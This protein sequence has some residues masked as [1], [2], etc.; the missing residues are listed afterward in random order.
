MAVP[1]QTPYIEHIGNGVTTSFSLGFQ[2]ESKDHLIVLVD[3]IEPPI[4]TWSL[5]GGNVVF[6]IAPAAGKKI[7]AQ[8]NTPFSRNVDYQSY[9]NSFRPP[10]VNK[11]F[12]WIWWKLQELGVADWILGARIDALK[13]YVDRKDDELKAYL[14]E[15]IRKQ[16]VAL[17]QLDDY[18]N[19][20]MQRLA[21]IAVDKG[22]DASFVVDASGENQQQINDRIGN[23]WR[24]KPIGYSVNERVML[25]S[26]EVVKSIIAN[27]TNNPNVEM[28]GWMPTS[29]ILTFDMFGINKTGTVAVDA[30]IKKVAEISTALK[31]PIHQF[32]GQYLLNGSETIVFTENTLLDGSKLVL[33]PNFTGQII[34]QR[35]DEV[36]TEITSGT[37]FNAIKAVGNL[38]KGQTFIAPLSGNYNDHY[39]TLET[40]QPMYYYRG[41]LQT[42]FLQ[43][44]H[45]REGRLQSAPF[46]NLDLSKL[47][48][49][50]LSRANDSIR[51]Y[52]GF[53]FD[54]S[55]AGALA[56]YFKAQQSNM[57]A[58]LNTRY[59]N[60]G[61]E[62]NSSQTRFTAEDIY[63]L[64]VDRFD[65]SSPH[66]NPN[67]TFAYSMTLNRCYD[68]KIK[69]MLSQ[70]RGWG[71]IGN[72]NSTLGKFEDCDVNRIDFHT[73]CYE[74]LVIEN[75]RLGD[76]GIIATV[77]GNLYLNN[78]QFMMQQ[79]YGN[80]G[81][82][83][84]GSDAGGFCNGD[85]FINNV[86]INGYLGNNAAFINCREGGDAI[87]AGSPLVHEMFTN[88]YID[89][90]RHNGLS[91]TTATLITC[92]DITGTSRNMLPK[93]IH[94]S[95]C[96]SDVPP[97]MFDIHVDKFKL[98]P[99]GIDIKYSDVRT[100]S[101]TFR[102]NL[103]IGTK[104]R[105][106][107][108]NVS[109]QAHGLPTTLYNTANFD[110]DINNCDLAQYVEYVGAWTVYSPKI[111]MNGGS[112]VNT[113]DVAPFLTPSG[114][115]NQRIK[116]INVDFNMPAMTQL[117]VLYRY[118]AVSCWFNGLRYIP[119]FTD[120]GT[121]N[122]GSFTIDNRSGILKLL[123]E[124]EALKYETSIGL[125]A[126]TYNT[127]NGAT[128][129]VTVAGSTATVTVNA[130]GL[131]LIGLCG[132]S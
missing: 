26:G 118:Q 95:D 36:Q 45:F 21:Q 82:I 92:A 19:Y 44:R 93:R 52:S 81:F 38:F 4:A 39:M 37:L 67:G 96:S 132:N 9:N 22:W 55:S 3:E 114:V 70:G 72:N 91:P 115:H 75:C 31:I 71:T 62:R 104:A 98:R 123:L 2:C 13:N 102:D 51:V 87:P 34:C 11:D 63:N 47:T 56:D 101:I 27:N 107:L 33:G 53:C 12:D 83:R 30:Q 8:R 97:T 116:A 16:G 65:T 108:I 15:E 77:V 120:G 42:A 49:I 50:K 74:K 54:E 112:L 59:V 25:E 105:V 129:V 7:T 41:V 126:G 29:G 35:N 124:H 109:G 66:P 84:S 48:K 43:T 6:T 128:V 73:A 127:P 24:S 18:Y 89:G 85:L 131:K 130:T 32:S 17:E 61:S 57:V 94:L 78:V 40:S 88:V 58:V 68:F 122:T 117:A 80:R 28:T 64:L 46:F 100:N 121:V 14:M 5:F 76:F 99:E 79:G 90:L 119:M 10:A 106:K 69:N 110:L 125:A 111:T 20:L 86:T 23:Y 1:E 103:G 113:G 60:R